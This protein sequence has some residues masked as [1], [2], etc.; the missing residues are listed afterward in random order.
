[1]AQLLV[2]S[3]YAAPQWEQ[4]RA[5]QNEAAVNAYPFAI[6]ASIGAAIGFGPGLGGLLLATHGHWSG[7]AAGEFLDLSAILIFGVR[8]RR[9]YHRLV[10]L[11]H[12]ELAVGA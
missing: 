2:E 3:T 9:T 11:N 4:M 1:M 12:S 10:K 7:F 6:V 8:S 5:Q